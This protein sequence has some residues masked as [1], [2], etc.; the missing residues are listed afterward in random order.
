[1]RT[2]SSRAWWFEAALGHLLEEHR[3]LLKDPVIWNIEEGRK[4][5]GIQIAHVEIKRTVLYHRVRE[6]METYEFLL[7]AS[8]VPPSISTHLM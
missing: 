5:T 1:M 2:R 7:P 6:F 8:Q 3:H 4:L